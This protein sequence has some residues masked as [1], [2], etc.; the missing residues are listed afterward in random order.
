MARSVMRLGPVHVV[1]VAPSPALRTAIVEWLRTNKRVRI[2]RTAAS[3]AELGAHRVDCDLV[4]ASALDG[5]RELRAIGKRFGTSAGLVALSLGTTPL[6]AGWTG[7]RPGASQRHVL[8]QAVPHPERSVA[9]SWTA[10]SAVVVALA[11]LL[12]SVVYVPPTGVS[13]QR[14]A[15][16]YADRFP[17]T[18]TWW[19]IWGTGAPLLASP[20][21]PLL[22]MGSLIGGGPEVFVLLAAVV[23]AIYAVALLLLAL[24]AGARRWAIAVALAGIV[25]PAVWVWPRGGDVSSLAGLAAV[26]LALAGSRV[27]RLRLTAVAVAVALASF[28][29]ILWVLAAALIAGVAGV[30]S[31]RGRAG[32]AGALLGVLISVAVTVP[33]FLSRGLDALRPPLARTPA[34]SD[35]VPVLMSAALVVVVIASGRARRLAVAIALVVAVA[36]NVLALAVPVAEVDVPNVRSTGPF[37]RLLMHPAQALAM[38]ARE[39][40]LPTTGNDVSAALVLGA[41]PKDATNA[42]LEWLGVDRALLPDRSSAIIYNE[43]DWSVIDRDRLL[44]SAPR[45]RPVL[46]AAITPTVL[47][48]GDDPDATLFGEALAHIGVTSDRLVP[49]RAGQPLDE[50]DRASLRSFTVLVIY[51]QPWKDRAKA[52]KALDDFLQQSGFVFMDA[53]GRAGPQLVVPE[54]RTFPGRDVSVQ[55]E[56]QTLIAGGSGYD[57]RVVGIDRF[58]YAGDPTWERSALV[59]GDKRLIQFGR[60]QVKGSADTFA[61][62]VWSGV[63][64]PRRAAAHDE[65]ALVQLRTALEWLLSAAAAA[66]NLPPQPPFA[67]PGTG[68]V[69]DSEAFTSSM[70]SPTS[71]RIVL[72][73]QTTGVLFKTRYNGQ[74]RAYQIDVMPLVQRESRTVLPIYRTTHGYMFVNLSA[75][76]RIVDFVFERHPLEPATRAVSAVALFAVLGVTFFQWRR[77]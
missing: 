71:W 51:G 21:W 2:V 72:K 48:V 46:S 59:A 27:Q 5:T 13:Y 55:G 65:H 8:D 41:E 61:H 4:V 11:A 36:A 30:R 31:R 7:V 17:D 70:T 76:A 10:I 18:G 3:A 37:G 23:A 54:A 73:E 32:V 69:V 60:V 77:R 67:R 35:A 47:V 64:L 66:A 22:K 6:P 24:R 53:A 9:A 25:T 62:M 74:W 45:V 57:G 49:I 58:T 12:V 52:E 44:L 40:D 14:A 28:A 42:T 1:V 39:P 56:E 43:R 68:D 20:A 26:V 50:I 63:D 15:L 34:L 19:H 75:N 29:G 33:P 38:A 16:A